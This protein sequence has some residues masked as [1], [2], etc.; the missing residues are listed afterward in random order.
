MGEALGVCAALAAGTGALGSLLG[1]V[2]A[3]SGYLPASAVAGGL[4]PTGVICVLTL[5]W[6]RSGQ[7]STPGRTVD[8]Q[9]G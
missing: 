4:F 3:G 9:S 1:G 7:P 5:H 8:S 6:A 2:V